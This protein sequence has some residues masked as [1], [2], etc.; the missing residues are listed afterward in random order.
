[1]HHI[2][3]H[4]GWDSGSYHQ[5]G[6]VARR[7]SSDGGST[8]SSWES[9][10]EDR[11]PYNN[12]AS[13]KDVDFGAYVYTTNAGTY[14][15]QGEQV[16]F[17]FLDKDIVSG[18]LYEYKLQFKGLTSTPLIWLN[19]HPAYNAQTYCRTGNSEWNVQEILL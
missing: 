7:Y 18:R 12:G 10:I 3:I 4:V 6:R 16:Q 1:M 11:N 9:A 17:S 13:Q 8:W 14:S 19:W 2:D 5:G 15:Y